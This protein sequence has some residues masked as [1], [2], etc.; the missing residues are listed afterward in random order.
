MKGYVQVYTGNGKGKTTA[1]IGQAI[2]AV[3]AGLSVLLIQF[4]KSKVYSEHNL[5]PHIKGITVETVGKPFFIAKEGMLSEADLK[6][7]GDEVVVFPPGKP[8]AEYEALIREGYERALTA[9][10]SGDYDMVILDEYN[11]ALFFGLL[12]WPET[13]ELLTK[14]RPETELIFTGRGA[15]PELIEAADLVTEMKEIKHYYEQ[16]VEARLGIEN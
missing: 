4:M 7:W 8:P 16:G 9:V 5:L 14:R 13:E 1:A 11:T 10:S 6:E 2:R 15:P 12:S 3:G